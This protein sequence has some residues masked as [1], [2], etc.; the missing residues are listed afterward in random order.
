MGIDLPEPLRWLFKLTGSEWPDADEDKIAHFGDLGQ[1]S[2]TAAQLAD[3]QNLDILFIAAGGFFTVTPE[4]AAQYVALTGSTAY[5]PIA[6]IANHALICP[7]SSLPSNPS[8][9]LR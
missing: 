8:K 9:S 7:Q 6:L 4:R 1:E 2:L 5:S 3:L